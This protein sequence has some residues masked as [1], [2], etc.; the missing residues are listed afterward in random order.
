MPKIAQNLEL[1]RTINFA[2]EAHMGQTRRYTGEPYVNHCKNVLEILN[3]HWPTAPQYVRKA[4][5]L[6]DVLEDTDVEYDELL[7]RFGVATATL[8]YQLTNQYDNPAFGN[9][10]RRKMLELNRMIEYKS[11]AVFAVKAADVI[12]NLSTIIRFDKGFARTYVAE[13]REALTKLYEA[14]GKPPCVHMLFFSAMGTIAGC[15]QALIEFDEERRH[16]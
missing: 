10:K 8:V 13:K 6:H 1:R 12:D 4:A 11:M 9:R 5:L 7:E 16:G 15:E 14:C 3:K 2:H